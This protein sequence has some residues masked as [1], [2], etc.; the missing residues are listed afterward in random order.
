MRFE[1]L[2]PVK[3]LLAHDHAVA[4]PLRLLQGSRLQLMYLHRGAVYHS[5]RRRE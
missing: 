4:V 5:H 2:L 3:R 1:L